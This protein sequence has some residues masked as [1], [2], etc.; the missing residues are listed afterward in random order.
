MLGTTDLNHPSSQSV[1][2]TQA[3]KPPPY[4]RLVPEMP[5]TLESF[6]CARCLFP[7]AA[8]LESVAARHECLW[9]ARERL[10]DPPWHW[11]EAGGHPHR[12]AHGHYDYGA[13]LWNC[14]TC[15][16]LPL[17]TWEL[18]E[19]ALPA[20]MEVDGAVGVKGRAPA[21]GGLDVGEGDGIAPRFPRFHRI[22]ES[23]TE[24]SHQL[25]KRALAV[26]HIPGF[27]SGFSDRPPQLT[28]KETLLSSMNTTGLPAQIHRSLSKT[29]STSRSISARVATPYR[30]EAPG[31][32]TSASA[33]NSAPERTRD[34][35]FI[36]IEVP[37][38]MKLPAYHVAFGRD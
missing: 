22:H 1:I 28:S 36:P 32:K 2:P 8:R 34:L 6:R 12:L 9:C 17:G 5:A 7:F 4:N 3:K 11:C 38:G 27:A 31:W 16:N 18:P 30:E 20:P 25:S 33:P 37:P 13:N 14:R 23:E 26:S 35:V 19:A 24:H 29:S 15:L 21:F 10:G